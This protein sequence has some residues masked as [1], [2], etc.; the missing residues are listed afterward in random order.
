MHV[1]RQNAFH[2][3]EEEA[4]HLMLGRVLIEWDEITRDDECFING[5]LLIQDVESLGDMESLYI[6]VARCFVVE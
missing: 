2:I 3:V 4:C 1:M 5:F 6:S